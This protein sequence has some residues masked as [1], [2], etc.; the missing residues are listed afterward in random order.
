M[1]DAMII[2]KG[3]MERG[4]AHASVYKTKT[5][6]LPQGK[7]GNKTDEFGNTKRSRSGTANKVELVEPQLPRPLGLWERGSIYW[8]GLR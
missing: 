2:N 1:E 4:F 8:R 7:G 5:I 6:D 3:S